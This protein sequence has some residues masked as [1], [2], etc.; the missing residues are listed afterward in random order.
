MGGSDDRRRATPE[1]ARAALDRAIE[2]RPGEV[3]DFVERLERANAVLDTTSLATS[4]LDDDLVSG[5]AET[6]SMLLG[7]GS[8]GNGSPATLAAAVG[9]NAADLER[10]LRKLSRLERNGTLDE[11]AAAGETLRKVEDAVDDDAVEL[12]SDP[13]VAADVARLLRAVE[14]AGDADDELGT[15]ATLRALRDEETQRG[16]AFLVAL[17]RALGEREADPD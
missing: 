6:S 12:A 8:D 4:A 3:L 11:L 9:A 1:E 5:L 13:E 15:L 16:L 7:G 17:A 2:E 10:A 14:T